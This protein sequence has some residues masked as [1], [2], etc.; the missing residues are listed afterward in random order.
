MALDA[1]AG[2]L[3]TMRSAISKSSA[4][5]SVNMNISAN[6]VLVTASPFLAIKVAT[7]PTLVQL[8]SAIRQLFVK[9]ESIGGK[10][11]WEDSGG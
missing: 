8:A 9:E 5:H 11:Q 6:G 1:L 7:V 3:R 4:E 10:I 2:P